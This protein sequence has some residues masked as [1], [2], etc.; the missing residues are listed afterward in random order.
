MSETMLKWAKVEKGVLMLTLNRPEV[1]NALCTELLGLLANRLEQAAEEDEFQCI[2]LSGGEKVFAAGADVIEIQDQNP[3]GAISDVRVL[4]W[5]SIRNFPKPMLAAV[6]GFCLGG[7]LEL[8]MCADV[9]IAEEG[10]DP[11]R[12]TL[13]F[14]TI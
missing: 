5:K 9:L 11:W 4:Y 7:G 8:A 6:N 10:Q 14:S 13:L 12:M 3:L 2:V 1:R